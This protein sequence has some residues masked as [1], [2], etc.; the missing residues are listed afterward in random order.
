M[1]AIKPDLLQHW[2]AQLDSI[3]ALARGLKSQA[4]YSGLQNV[5]RT[6]IHKVITMARAA[7]EHISGRSSAYTRRAEEILATKEWAIHK[8]INLL[9]VVESLREDLQAGHLQDVAELIHGE[10]F[11]DFLEMARHLLD[12]GYKDPAAVIA[13]SSLEAHLRQLCEK[14]GIATEITSQTEPYPKK[15]DAMNVDLASASAYSKL[16]QKNITA[17]LD[18]RNKAAHGRYNEYTKEQVSLMV[19]GVHDFIRRNPA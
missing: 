7:I 13:G 12:E 15:A 11:G 2:L 18:L 16:D 8:M 5:D 17:W 10:L 6:E 19:A 3:I 14:I 9:G 4:N 1:S